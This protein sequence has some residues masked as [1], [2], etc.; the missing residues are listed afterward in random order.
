MFFTSGVSIGQNLV[1]NGDFEQYS[2]CPNDDGQIDS[3]LFWMN[4]TVG[5]GTFGGTPDYFNQCSSSSQADVPQN[6]M[7]FQQPRSGNGYSGIYLRFVNTVA[8][9]RE[10]IETSLSSSLI[11]N[12]C[13]YFEMHFS[14]ANNHRYTSDAISVYFS[15]TSITGITNYASLPYIP[16]LNNSAGNFA[17]TLNWVSISGTYT[18]Q[19]GENYLIIGNFKSDTLT[20]FILANSVGHTNTSY[21]YIDDV[22]LTPCTNVE[23]ENDKPAINIYPNPTTDKIYITSTEN[24]LLVFE[25]HDIF[26]KTLFKYSFTNSTIINTGQLAK[27]IY[28]YDLRKQKAVIKKGKNVKE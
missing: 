5:G 13:Y 6:T 1:P 22:T 23:Q 17:D 4:P 18:A 2:G 24:D 9:Y 19:G 21:V 3:A 15:D 20:T 14:L 12:A 16:Q 8:E 7:G 11:A 27:G 26:G 28:F 10:Y 25:L